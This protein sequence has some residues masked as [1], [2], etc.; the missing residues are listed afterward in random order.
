MPIEVYRQ[1]VWVKSRLPL[2]LCSSLLYDSLVAF[3]I[4]N[5]PLWAALFFH[6][7]LLLPC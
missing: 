7:H 6:V 5:N 4:L 1:G 3:G 2:Y